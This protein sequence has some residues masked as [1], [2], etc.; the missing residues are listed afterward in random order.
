MIIMR[1]RLS[2]ATA[3]LMIGIG[4]AEPAWAEHFFF[5]TGNPDGRLGALSRRPSPGK[6]ETETADDFALTETTVISQAVIT[7]LIVPNTMPLASISQ[8]EVELYHVFPLDSDLS[9]T[10]RV[11][12]RVNSPA[13]VEIDT[14]TRDPLART[15]SFSSTLLN[16]SFTVANSVV[17]GINASPNQLTHGEG[18]QSGEEVAITINFTTPIILPAGHYFFRPEVLVNGGDFLY[19]SAPRPIV[20]PGTPFPAGVTDLQAWIRNANLN[21][22]WLRIGT[23]I[24]GIIPPATT[25]PTFNMTFSL[26]GDTVPE[27]GTPG[28]ANCHGKTISALARQFRGINAAVLALGASSVNDLQDSVGRFCNP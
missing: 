13:D 25:A 21:P 6:I 15:L 23:D 5:S 11:P 16:P 26:A 18:P 22:D 7:G 12:T 10:I 24:I 17:H 14:A 27:A 20:P 3:I 19:L 28:Q 2:L 8:V 9:R 4:L 1:S